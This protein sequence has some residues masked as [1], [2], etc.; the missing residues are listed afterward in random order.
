MGGLHQIPPL[1]AWES[2]GR[3]DRRSVE[4]R[5]NGGHHSQIKPQLNKTHVISQSLMQ[6]AQ[7]L[8]SSGP[9][10]LCTIYTF[11]FSTF[12]GLLSV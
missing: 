10:S 5:E 6:Q 7:N 2:P 1:R 9:G 4:T 3:G 8:Y 11:H 12:M